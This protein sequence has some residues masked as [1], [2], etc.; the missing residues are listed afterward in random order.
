M[1]NKYKFLSAL[2][3]AA[4]F[5][6]GWE[7]GIS[8][9][10]QSLQT[11]NK[12]KKQLKNIVNSATEVS[13]PVDYISQ[14]Q[15]LIDVLNYDMNIDLYPSDKKLKGD[16]TITG[17]YLNKNLKQIDLNFYDNMKIS[18]CELNG[19]PTDYYE[20]NTRLSIPIK[21]KIKSDT[22]KVRIVYEGTPEKSRISPGLF[23]VR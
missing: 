17:K 6:I 8:P 19:S 10:Q 4:I 9:I 1:R 13:V 23:L 20:K 18:E 21:D 3:F 16:V 22:F 15:N 11:I 14:N 7:F 2:L 12:S 5:F